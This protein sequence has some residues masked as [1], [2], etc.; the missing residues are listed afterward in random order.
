MRSPI[1]CAYAQV[2]PVSEVPRI[3]R[4]LGAVGRGLITAGVVVLLFV[5]FQLWGT[6]IQEARSQTSLRSEFEDVVAGAQSQLADLEAS[7]PADGPRPETPPEDPETSAPPATTSTLPGGLTPEVLRFFFPEDGDAVARI[8]IPSI[9]VD[10]IV[11]N[12]VQ[13]TDLRKGPGHY[14]GTAAV[15]TDGNTSIAGHRTTYG[16]PFNRIDELEPGDEI[17]VTGVLGRF[18]YRVMEP[19]RA[20]T[21]EIDTVD[22]LDAGHIIVRPSATWVLGD[23]GD[24]RVTLTACHPK[25]SS[26]QRII[27]AAELVDAPI[28]AP[29]FDPEVVATLVGDDAPAPTI[30]TEDVTGGS[31]EADADDLDAGL[32]GER[33]AIPGAVLWLVAATTIWVL[34]GVLGRRYFEQRPQRIAA[35]AAGLVPA[36][37]CLWFAFEMIDRA[38]PAG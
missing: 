33:D 23:F 15:G 25:L 37:I 18:T 8:E 19:Q 29:E 4:V 9:G 17:H 28:E 11:V 35:R 34:A 6:N 3:A 22:T 32:N 16:A 21:A 7:E 1:G 10:K 2:S 14:P 26:R 36:A 30:P 38:L 27:V 20:F 31:P 5:V 12:G 13:V 24:N